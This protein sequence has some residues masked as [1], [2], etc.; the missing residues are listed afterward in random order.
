[1]TTFPI[2]LIT[3][4]SRG[5]G[6][7]IAEFLLRSGYRVMGCSRGPGTIDHRDYHHAQVDLADE[8]AVR[9]W[10][11]RVGRDEKRIDV[12]VN[13]AGVGPATPALMTSSR[14][15]QTALQTNFAATAV[16]CQEAAKVM[17]KRKFGRI[18]NVSSMV[19]R[20]HVEGAAAYAS[21]K[22]AVEE[23]TKILAKELAPVGVT[24]N[25]LALSLID[26]DMM[27]ALSTQARADYER[28]LVMKRP[29]AIEDVCHAV[30]FL[31][32]PES[33][34]VTGQILYLGFVA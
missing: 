8:E 24:C 31:I 5:V 22:A 2:A 7:G 28:H 1:M 20:L 14:L 15:M 11:R 33:R 30:S 9:D 34:Q 6:R 27:K 23:Y 12:V 32:H 21:S 29:L 26:T 10:V 25:V 16:V 4:T 19:A 13:N 3:G 18:V 17:L